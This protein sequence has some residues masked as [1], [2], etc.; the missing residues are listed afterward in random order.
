VARVLSEK[1]NLEQFSFVLALKEELVSQMNVEIQTQSLFW[2]TLFYLNSLKG[3]S[4]AC[5]M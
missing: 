1:K 4:S 5:V 2:A 3:R